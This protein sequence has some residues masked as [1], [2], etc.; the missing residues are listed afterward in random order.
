MTPEISNADVQELFDRIIEQ[1]KLAGQEM[2]CWGP[3]S[4]V[5]KST[6]GPN[7]EDQVAIKLRHSTNPEELLDETRQQVGLMQ[8][9]RS[10]GGQVLEFLDE[11]RI[12]EGKPGMRGAFV[13]TKSRFLPSK[14]T[15]YKYGGAIA[16]M[17]NASKQIDLSDYDHMDPLVSISNTEIAIQYLKE[18]QA[19][20]RPFQVGEIAVT[21]AQIELVEQMFAEATDIRQRLFATAKKNGSPLVVVQEDVYTNNA[22]QSHDGTGTLIDVDA[23]IGPAA[24]DFGR[25]LNDMPRF[26][27]TG[28]ITDIEAYKTGYQDMVAGGKLPPEDELALAMQYSDRRT[29]LLQTTLAV[30]A[31]RT[32]HNGDWWLLKQG[33]YR[34][35]TIGKP[36]MPWYSDTVERRAVARKDL[37]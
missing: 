2:I 5:V 1:E 9:V 15:E 3:P 36:E 18:R 26:V 4:W 24:L 28:S 17:H 8:Q 22:G 29:P 37:Q 34:L 14:T 21:A 20:G 32:G 12:I 7:P 33:L 25:M 35:T 31:I 19:Q 10:H 16:S 6:T 13:S 27:E 23:L 30:N 11:P